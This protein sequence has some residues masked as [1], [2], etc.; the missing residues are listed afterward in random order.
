MSETQ[1]PNKK[2]IDLYSVNYDFTGTV[3]KNSEE[4]VSFKSDSTIRIWFN[5]LHRH[6]PTHWHSALE[7]I[8][9]V[10][11]YYDA[12]IDNILYH[13][14]PEEILIIPPGE[15][16]SLSAPEEGKRFIYLIDI[17][18]FSKIKGFSSIQSILSQPLHITKDAYPQIYDELYSYLI[19]MKD[20][21]F[22]KSNYCELSIYSLLLNLF[23]KLGYNRMDTA[24][25]FPNVHSYKQ[26]EYVQKFNA[27]LEYIDSND[28]DDLNLE[29][30]ASAIGFSKYHFSRLFKQYTGFTFCDYLNY[31]RIKIAEELLAQPDRSITEIALQSGFSS[32]STFN[33]IFKQQKHCTPSEYRAKSSQSD[34]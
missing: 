13:I 28:T 15:L 8:L 2:D 1:N 7:I 6:F 5:D 30:T 20:E 33:R 29:N 3:I 16:H 23:A 22:S 31:R 17:S 25:P 18:F 4:I 32:I 24:N 11:N 26:K 12:Y 9:P 27:L 10:E 14:F 21:Y 19:Q 34:L